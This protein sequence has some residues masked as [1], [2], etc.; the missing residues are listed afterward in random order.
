M[1]NIPIDMPEDAKEERRLMAAKEGER[2]QIMRIFVSRGIGGIDERTRGLT[3]RW[4]DMVD[5]RSAHVG[6]ARLGVSRSIE[7][8]AR[9]LEG[10]VNLQHPARIWVERQ[11]NKSVVHEPERLP[12]TSECG[13]HL[14]QIV[15][16]LK[17]G[18]EAAAEEAGW[19]ATDPS[20]YLQ[21][22]C[23]G[24]AQL[25]SREQVNSEE[26]QWLAKQVGSRLPPGWGAM[27]M[28]R[29]CSKL[30]GTPTDQLQLVVNYLCAMQ[31]TGV[32]MHRLGE[33]FVE[34]VSD[35]RRR[36]TVD[37]KAAAPGESLEFL[38]HIRGWQS[39]VRGKRRERLLQLND[40]VSPATRGSAGLFPQE[41]RRAA[42]LRALFSLLLLCFSLLRR[43]L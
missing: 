28:K 4:F 38:A 29:G 5:W 19:R 42:P 7:G 43:S 33:S 1:Q 25:L 15:I 13:H 20:R 22:E 21:R 14:L 35:V 17:Q 30:E 27:W 3:Q 37:G 36:I 31:V 34:N 24:L 11:E 9:K 12:A 18:A 26:A 16:G 32:N 40:I 41:T 23:R 10:E 2:T 39:E 6:K 8:Y